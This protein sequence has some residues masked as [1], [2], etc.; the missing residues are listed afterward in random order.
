MKVLALLN[1]HSGCDYHRIRLPLEYLH[2]AGYISGVTAPTQEE[3]LAQCDILYYNRIPYGVS[4]E[5]VL[6]LRRKHGFKIVVDVDDYWKLYPGHMLT[7]VWKSQEMEWKIVQSLTAADA[8]TCTSDRLAEKV[9]TYNRNVYVV[10]NGLPFG[11]GQF[12]RN[13]PG[14]EGLTR[15]VYA[16]G[17]SH[18]WDVRLLR[19][20]ARRL[21]RE[22]FTGE[23]VLAGVAEGIK[24][25]DDMAL[26][27]SAN[28]ALK[29]FRTENHLPLDSYMDLYSHG[30]V[31]LAPLVA[32]DFNA[33]KSNLKVIEAGCKGMPII[34]SN[35]P[36]Y[37]DDDNPLIMRVD[38][39][40]DWHRWIRYC[41]F[42]P[43]F[44]QDTGEA[45][46]EFVKR[47]Y[48]L[49]ILNFLR[50]EAFKSVL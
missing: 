8:V 3:Q 46:H 17:G 49:R 22:P 2:E 43:A 40:S 5:T 27:M 29:Q 24:I 31:A 16:G 12:T 30:D 10:P 26:A 50:L 6:A 19:N 11:E 7:A 15:F 36:P 1:K 34:C 18:L 28:G 37:R 14:P 35:V 45:M 21:A 48:E 44:V 20:T 47:N 42:N 41:E 32:N 4:M 38:T 25:Y 33:C 9:R 23:L 13:I 39:P